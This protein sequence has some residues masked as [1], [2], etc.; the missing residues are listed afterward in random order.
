MQQQQN[1]PREGIT[2]QHNEDAHEASKQH[3]CIEDA[4]N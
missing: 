3:P 4:Q 2:Q 1:Q